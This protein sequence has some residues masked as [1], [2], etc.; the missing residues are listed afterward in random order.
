MQRVHVDLVDV[1]PLLAV[2]LDVDEQLVHQA[3]GRLV[4]EALVRHHVAPVTGGVS[5]REQNWFV[6]A[7]RFG[8]RLRSPGPPVDRIVPVLQQIGR[9]LVRETILMRRIEYGWHSRS[10]ARKERWRNPGVGALRDESI[11]D[12]AG[13]SSGLR[14]TDDGGN[15]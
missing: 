7:L 11:A 10:V 14:T 12:F 2:D 8:Q 15:A 13:A 9:G 6:G 4:L 1:G 5:D 3:C